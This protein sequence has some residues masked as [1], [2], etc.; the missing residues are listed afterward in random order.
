MAK[1]AKST[2][3]KLPPVKSRGS[4]RAA[5]SP[6]KRQPRAKPVA[7]KKTK[8]PKT[9]KIIS[10]SASKLSVTELRA[11]L[12]KLQRANATLRAKNREASRAT[13]T[14]AARIAEL[15]EE[16]ARLQRESAPQPAPGNRG[17]TLVRAK[18][19]SRRIDPGDAVPPAVAVEEPATLDD[20]AETVRKNLEAHLTDG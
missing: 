3:A 2:K 6:A 5:A 9:T 13:R 16:V 4:I 8:T 18:R 17:P 10:A 7:S 15:E 14:A 12:E 19:Q 1:T 11:Q 20:E